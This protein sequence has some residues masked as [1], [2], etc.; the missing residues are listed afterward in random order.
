MYSPINNQVISGQN[1]QKVVKSQ[2]SNAACDEVFVLCSVYCWSS[3]IAPSSHVVRSIF[4]TS[5][6]CN[7]T[8]HAQEWCFTL[9]ITVHKPSSVVI[10]LTDIIFMFHNKA[11]FDWQSSCNKIF[12]AKIIHYVIFVYKIMILLYKVCEVHT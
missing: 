10:C 7:K 1:S 2:A 4:W 8:A 3:D 6:F 11:S 12:C 5:D 9:K